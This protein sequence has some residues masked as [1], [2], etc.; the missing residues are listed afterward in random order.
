MFLALA[1]LVGAA[2]I[3]L[4]LRDVFYQ[5][6]RPSGAGFISGMLMGGVWRALRPIARRFP[7]VLTLAGPA[8]LVFIIAT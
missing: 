4:T 6:F 1:T 2:L 7:S 8:A 3:F 5:L